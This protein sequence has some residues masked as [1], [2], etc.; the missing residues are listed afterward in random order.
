MIRTRVSHIEKEVLHKSI[1]INAALEKVWEV[2]INDHYNR[3][4][5]SEFNRGAYIKTDWKLGSKIMLNDG[6]GYG[7]VGRIVQ[8]D[9][10]RA[11]KMEYLGFLENGREDLYSADARNVKG[12]TE[13]Y[14]LRESK[15]ITTLTIV[16][17]TSAEHLELFKNM[18]D[19]ALKKIKQLGETLSSDL[20][21]IH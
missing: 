19:K 8:I 13:A 17:E 1:S 15:G 5:Y 7:L 18:W 21:S 4:W 14:E 20:S 10:P 9:P 3:I 6:N 2:L 16:Q 12:F 11:F